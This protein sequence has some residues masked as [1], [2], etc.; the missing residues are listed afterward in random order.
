MSVSRVW[1]GSPFEEKAGY[2]RAVRV[3]DHIWVAATAPFNDDGTVT[4][5]GDLRGQT[6]RALEIIAEALE[7]LGSGIYDVVITRMFVTDISR[8]SELSE[9]HREVFAD[10]PPAATLVEVS[11]LV[12]PDLLIEIEVEAVVTNG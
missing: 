5:V 12:H 6:A 8:A 9:A 7:E 3:D 11:A 2:C 4:S 1:S 10:H